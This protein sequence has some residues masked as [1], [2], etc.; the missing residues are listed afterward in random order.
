M[1]LNSKAILKVLS[2]V[3]TVVGAAMLLP[4]FFAL[5]FREP[6]AAKSFAYTA[7]PMLVIG[8]ALF[9][10]IKMDTG[11][12]LR[13]RDGVLLVAV[14]WLLMS[15]IGA[16]PFVISG[17]IPNFIDAMFETASGFSTS[18]ASILRDVEW[19]PRSILL[20]RSLTH[21]LGGMGVLVLTVALLP[22]LGIGGQ[23][24]V[25]AESTGPTKDKALFTSTDSA[26][27]LY[28]V[29]IIFTVV[30]ALLL[31]AGGMTVTDSLI[32]TFGTVG[33]GGFS[34]YNASIGHYGSLYIE[35]VITVF[36]LLCSINFNINY[37]IFR[38]RPSLLYKDRETLF[39][40]VTFASAAVLL[41]VLLRT[42]GVY[43]T[44]GEALRNA[45]FTAAST[46]STTGY[47]ILNTDTWPAVCKQVLIVLMF[48]GGSAGSTA[49][50]FKLI[51]IIL[52]GK[53]IR[54]GINQRLHPNAVTAIKIQ[55]KTVPESVISGVASYFCLF[56][57]LLLFGTFV[58]SFEQSDLLAAFT[59]TLSCLSNVGPALSDAGNFV[60]YDIYSPLSKFLLTLFMIAGRL[61][62]YTLLLLFTPRYWN[63]NK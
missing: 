18:G 32:H 17:S 10:S 44:L 41:T 33:T 40:F 26:R 61:E 56:M 20:W 19:L 3:M 37:A 5:Y 63:K 45:S 38:G 35:V 15:A 34:S 49:G 1:L 11:A 60:V 50:G 53:I 2:A 22:K 54:R 27:A 59:S 55:G 23:K 24:I 16:L 46:M 13:T 14:S 30:L 36:M 48:F 62:V 28:I 57:V 25:N 31:L 6:V 47:G 58:L 9:L 52:L 21:W 8:V 29:Y 43:D 7:V 4:F 12:S 39:M 42:Y 51:R